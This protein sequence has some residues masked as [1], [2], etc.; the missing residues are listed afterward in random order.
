MRSDGHTQLPNNCMLLIHTFSL[1][2]LQLM[3]LRRHNEYAIQSNISF[4]LVVTKRYEGRRVTSWWQP[5]TK[6]NRDTDRDKTLARSNHPTT[7]RTYRRQ[8]DILCVCVCVCVL[9]IIKAEVNI[10][11]ILSKIWKFLEVF[12]FTKRMKFLLKGRVRCIFRVLPGHF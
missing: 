1:L 9:H 5:A 7:S 6:T 8:D 3:K 2:S 12:R 11:G 10:H 4:P